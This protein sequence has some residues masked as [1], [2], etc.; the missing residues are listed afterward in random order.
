[1]KKRERPPAPIP[2]DNDPLAPLKLPADPPRPQPR[3]LFVA[4]VLWLLW[5]GFLIVMALGW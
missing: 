2:D 3:W 4:V 5:L 1:M